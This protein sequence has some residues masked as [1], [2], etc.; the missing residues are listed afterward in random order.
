[1]RIA[2]LTVAASLVFAAS[3]SAGDI[4]VGFSASDHSAAHRAAGGKVKGKIGGI[5]AD[6]VSVPDGQEK[7]FI[8]RYKRQA[9]VRYAE[10]DVPVYALTDDPGFANQWYLHSAGDIDVDQ[11]EAWLK[12]GAFPAAVKVAVLDTG[13]DQD[14]RDLPPLSARGPQANFSSSSRIDDLYGH[15]THVAGTIA[16]IADNKLGVSGVAP[17]VVLLNGKVLGD[18]GSGSCSGVA[19][20]MTW[21][22]D[23]GARVISMSLGGG[24]CVAQENAAAYAAGKGSLVIAAAGNSSTSSP[25]YPAFYPSV[26]AVAATDSADQ[27]ASFSNFGSW[28]DI[29]APG[30]NIYSTMPNHTSK[31]R[32]KNYG[33]LSGTSMATPVVSG[34][35]ALPALTDVNGSGGTAD[36]LRS[37][38]LASVDKQGTISSTKLP[39]AG[40]INACR[41]VGGSGC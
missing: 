29:A 31:L 33:Y 7:A 10:V 11:P 16:A 15:G 37:L 8:E 32:T 14:H 18:S 9:G 1:M 25:S 40:R 12:R 5:N 6:V 35:A 17:N 36:E 34:I 39:N 38:L 20:G 22:A 3:A 41:V 30:V 13:I 4:I 26:L 24:S 28:V 2:L 23:Q 19:N 27:I 21:A